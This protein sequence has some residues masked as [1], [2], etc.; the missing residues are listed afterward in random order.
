MSEL[1]SYDNGAGVQN[2]YQEEK[3]PP[4]ITTRDVEMNAP[5]PTYDSLY[6]KL[7]AAN[8]NS[9]GKA[10]FAKTAMGIICGSL[11]FIICIGLSLAIPITEIVIGA[12][13][14]HDCPAQRLIPIYLV[15]AG[16][17]GTLKGIGLIGQNVKARKDKSNETGDEE[18][19][20]T[21]NPFDSI[22]NMF[23]FA[24]FI[25]GNV[26][27]YGLKD[28]WVSSP[29]TAGNYCHPTLYYF[30]FWVIT[31]TYIMIGVGCLFGCIGLICI[32]CFAA[33]SKE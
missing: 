22:V 21:T 6:G 15:V 10:D 14:I 11:V 13:F 8:E 4:P 12:S 32:C 2:S 17:F 29:S 18:K 27:V 24:W 26:W 31:L 9:S 1:P 25:C 30:S 33:K 5:P 19:K 28:Q 23:L 7:K 16:V 3:A 20:S